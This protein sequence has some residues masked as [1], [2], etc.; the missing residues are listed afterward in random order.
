MNKTVNINL[1]GIFFYMDENAYKILKNY[2]NAI[3]RSLSDDQQGKDE[4]IKDIEQRIGELLLE[5]ITQERQVIDEENIQ[6]II[7]IMG[8][9]EEYEGDEPNPNSEE[10]TEKKSKHRKKLYRDG[11]DRFLGGVSSGLGHYFG[12][13][14]T[15]VRLAFILLS[16]FG[17]FAIP[18]YVIFWILIPE[19]KTTAEKLEMVGEHVTIDNI[20]KKIR[21][22]F[23]EVSEKF[24][25]TDFRKLK[26]RSQ[27]IVHLIGDLVGAIFQIVKRFTGILLMFIAISGIIVF[28]IGTTTIG[29]IEIFNINGNIIDTLFFNTSI[30]KVILLIAFLTGIILP[31]IFIFFIGLKITSRKN[32]TVNKPTV[33]SLFILWLIAASTLTVAGASSVSSYAYKGS[34]TEKKSYNFKEMDTLKIRVINDDALWGNYPL[35]RRAIKQSVLV[36]NIK[37]NYSNDIGFDVLP[38]HEDRVTIIV[39]KHSNGRNRKNAVENASEIMYK[40]EVD[41]N[42]IVL[43]GYFLSSR[44]NL[45]RD[46]E[47]SIYIK[48]PNNMYVYFE[49]STFSFLDDVKNT[50]NIYDGD[51]V[52]QHF[53]MKPNGFVCTDCNPNIYRN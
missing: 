41:D 51:M 26:N 11:E 40:Y 50:K 1:G 24:K 2:L 5:K 16:L 32:I 23:E 12:I 17:G 3:A 42:E 49:Q 43:D 27:K 19:A 9:P 53:V 36:D 29:S 30:P 34:K 35:R 8:Q 37:M 18:A 38:S 31:F 15:W 25:S 10:S 21:E 44:D 52:N 20:E 48:I 47:V 39:K 6:D 28:S 46:E 22:E 14:S 33:I 45:Y 13:D 4:I 7:K